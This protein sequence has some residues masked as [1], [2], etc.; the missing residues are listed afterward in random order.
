M[1]V[2]RGGRDKCIASCHDIPRTRRILSSA[3]DR[4]EKWGWVVSISAGRRSFGSTTGIPRRVGR[5]WTEL[6]ERLY[7]AVV[8]IVPL[9][10]VRTG[11]L[12]AC[13][14]RIAD[15]AFVGAES[16]VVGVRGLTIGENSRSGRR[17]LLDARG[18]LTIGRDTALGHGVHLITA[19]HTVNT[20]D[21]RAVTAPISIGDHVWLASRTT[22]VMGVA[23]ADGAV[24]NAASL[25][26]DD[27]GPRAVV[28]GIP[29][30]TVGARPP[31][32]VH[33]RLTSPR[34][35]H[36]TRTKDHQ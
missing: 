25:V 19:Q 22:V 32:A 21:F 11:W 1:I 26:R 16:R 7:N 8:T 27:V 17:C 12:R 18:S 29:A 14:A 33:Y 5:A 15:G 30:R 4:C 3:N 9:R 36:L 35:R 31:E 2:C 6:G 24:V 28:A 20:A 10:S 23:V 13:G 34:I